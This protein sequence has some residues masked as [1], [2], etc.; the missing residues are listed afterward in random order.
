LGRQYDKVVCTGVLHHLKDPDAGLRA[1]RGV[2]RPGGAMVLMVYGTYGRTGIYMLQDYCRRLGLGASKPE[3]EEL[4]AVLGT[5]PNGHPLTHILRESP[6]LRHPH[7]LADALLHPR[8][9]AYTVP[10]LFGFV[11]RNGCRFGRWYR[12]AQYLPQCGALSG[13]PHGVRLAKLPVRDQY[14]A[15]ELYRGTIARHSLVAYRREDASRTQAIMPGSDS[16]RNWCKQVPIRRHRTICVQRNLPEGAAGVLINQAHTYTDLFL[17]VDQLEKRLYEA[18]DGKKTI[19]EIAAS[20]SAGSNGPIQT[21]ATAFFRRLYWYDQVVFDA[22][23]SA[24]P[25]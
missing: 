16:G 25:A 1:L 13:T 17:P 14:A 9:R 19:A 4:I 21:R 22:S 11:E 5:L 24:R 6:D 8:D 23:A 10:Q 7:G 2:L 3:L 15:V 20:A 18:I 12:Q